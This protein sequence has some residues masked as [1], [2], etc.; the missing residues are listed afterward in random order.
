MEKID[1][2]ILKQEKEL[3]EYRKQSLANYVKM[4]QEIAEALK[5]AYEE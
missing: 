4:E 2:E 1:D 5:A 3:E